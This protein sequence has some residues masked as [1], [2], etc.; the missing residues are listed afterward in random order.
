[1]MFSSSSLKSHS[2]P[3]SN[4][5]ARGT[6]KV[7]LLVENTT[8][9][10]KV[11]AEHGLAWWIDIDGDK[12]VLF[13]TGQGNALMHNAEILGIPLD[14]RN[15]IVL[16]HG[17]YDHAGGLEQVLNTFG[18]CP[19]WMHSAALQAKYSA[20]T[21][22]A[23]CISLPF[24]YEHQLGKYQDCIQTFPKSGRTEIVPHLFCTGEIPRR[25]DLEDT[26]GPFFLDSKLN[27]P[28]PLSDDVA[29]YFDTKD[30]IVVILGCCH[31]GILNTLEYIKE[32]TGNTRPIHAV[33]GGMHLLQ[34]S[35]QRIQKTIEG[36]NDADIDSLFPC[37][38]TG[39]EAS[40]LLHQALPEKVKYAHVGSHWQFDLTI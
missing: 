21:G 19:V 39:D 5:D 37:H 2:S 23:R 6:V 16:S 8:Q 12:R 11:L 4:N 32:Q 27:L 22:S 25:I 3:T 31:S 9:S 36:L 29:L 40:F 14:K 10:P 24:L 30:G 13:D 33:M 20:S 1:M 26:G 7:T 17:H 28:D 34:A 35:K 38:C 18:P 15:A